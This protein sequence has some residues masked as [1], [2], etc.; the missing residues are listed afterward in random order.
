MSNYP[1]LFQPTM[2]YTILNSMQNIRHKKELW[3]S[4]GLLKNMK[5]HESPRLYHKP[6]KEEFGL[7]GYNK[8]TNT[9][10]CEGGIPSS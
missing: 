2:G 4:F 5:E 7:A 10:L 9:S 8:Y 1:A 3:K 6:F